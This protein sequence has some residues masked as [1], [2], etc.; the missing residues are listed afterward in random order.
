M[1]K[2]SEH[3]SRKSPRL[4]EAT[5]TVEIDALTFNILTQTPPPNKNE[6]PAKKGGTSQRKKHVTKKGKKSQ[7]KKIESPANQK[8]QKRKGKMVEPLSNSDS[9]FVSEKKDDMFIVKINDTVLRFGVKEFEADIGLKCGPRIAKEHDS[10]TS[11]Y[12]T[13]RLQRSNSR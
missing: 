9:D 6:S 8:V 3:T 2:K 10:D 5:S 1:S 13:P 11:N 4:V 12:L 7:A